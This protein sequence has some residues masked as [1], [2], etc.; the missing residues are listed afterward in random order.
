V[1]ATTVP[2]LLVQGSMPYV[3]RTHDTVDAPSSTQCKMVDRV[4]LLAGLCNG[5]CGAGMQYV[6]WMT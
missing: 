1:T 4:G 3:C 6:E 2:G 5:L